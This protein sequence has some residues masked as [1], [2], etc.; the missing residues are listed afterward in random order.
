MM[1]RYRSFDSKWLT[2]NI[3]LFCSSR[4]VHSV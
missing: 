2:N 4:A 3:L 1:G